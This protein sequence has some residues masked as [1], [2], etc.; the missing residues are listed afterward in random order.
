LLPILVMLPVF[1]TG[2]GGS[3]ERDQL[4]DAYAKQFIS[5]YKKLTEAIYATTGNKITDNK[6]TDIIN[7]CVS[8]TTEEINDEYI[9]A[10]TEYINAY[11]SDRKA[12]ERKIKQLQIS[13]VRQVNLV[14]FFDGYMSECVK[15]QISKS[16]N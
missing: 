3:A 5:T 4:A 8:E 16:M 7:D 2:C 9:P 1:L 13:D 10:L 12:A 11:R 15:K 6:I 14:V